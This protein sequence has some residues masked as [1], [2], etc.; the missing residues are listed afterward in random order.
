[1]G[2]T[3]DKENKV[4]QQPSLSS[5]FITECPVETICLLSR[6]GALTLT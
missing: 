1:M 3:E 5:T 4:H 2:G 6:Y